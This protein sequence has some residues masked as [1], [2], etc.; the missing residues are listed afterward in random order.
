MRTSSRGTAVESSP[1]YLSEVHRKLEAGEKVGGV[2]WIGLPA[3]T[4]AGVQRERTC[5]YSE[6]AVY[7]E[8]WLNL[9]RCL[10]QIC[11]SCDGC[12][13]YLDKPFYDPA[14]G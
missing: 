14:R 4:E 9:S 8:E 2:L 10:K 5:R 7:G 12:F 1:D 13:R 11:Y 3:Q 6:A